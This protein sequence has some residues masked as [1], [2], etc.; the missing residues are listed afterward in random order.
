MATS[1]TLYNA[2]KC[3]NTLKLKKFP[4]LKNLFDYSMYIADIYYKYPLKYLLFVYLTNSQTT[5]WVST[6]LVDTKS[7]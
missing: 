1:E 2:L 7:L 6:L 3:F 4:T 5:Q